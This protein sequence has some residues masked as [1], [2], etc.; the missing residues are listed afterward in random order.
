MLINLGTKIRALRQRD[1]RTQEALADALGITPQAVS[2]WEANGSYPDVEMIPA[3]ANYFHISIDELFGYRDD[4]EERIADIIK[5][6]EKSFP[7]RESFQ[8]EARRR[9]SAAAWICS[10]LPRRSFPT[11]R[12]SF[13]G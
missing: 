6:A 3:I 12:E 9:K 13:C 5:K 1:G 2:R 8:R 10:A 4:R 11:S 7:L